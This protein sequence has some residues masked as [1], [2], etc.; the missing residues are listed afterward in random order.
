MNRANSHN[1]VQIDP[2]G[3]SL[4]PRLVSIQDCGL[5]LGLSVHTIYTMVSQRRIPFVKVGRLVKFDLALLD[6]WI[7]KRTVMPISS[8]RP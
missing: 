1:P 4:R 3:L 2:P 5:Y 7:A 8:N 6:A